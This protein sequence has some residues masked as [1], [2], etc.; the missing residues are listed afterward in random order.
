MPNLLKAVEASIVEKTG[1]RVSIG[2]NDLPVIESHSTKQIKSLDELLEAGNF[3]KDEWEVERSKANVWHQ[4]SSDNGL[5]PLWQ[6]EAR[7][8]R[9]D[10]S[11]AFIAQL[12]SDGHKALKAGLNSTDKGKLAKVTK[13]TIKG[14]MVEFAL[15]DLHLGKFAWNEETG[16][17]NWDINLAADT[18]SD[19]MNDL[20]SRSPDAEEAWYIVGNDFF[21]VD[22]ENGTTTAGTPQDE[23]GR[24]QKTFA[25]GKEIVMCSIGKLRKKYPKVKVIVVYGNHD[26][27]RSFYLGEVLVEACRS[28]PNVEVD[29]R[30]LLRKYYQWGATGIGF[31]HGDRIK[32]KDL[33][34]LVQNEA[35]QIWGN[36]KRF[37]LHLGHL[38]Q[39]IV[40]TLG[41]VT[42]R[43]LPAL[44][45]PDAWHSGQGYTMAEKAAMLFVYDQ[46]GMRNLEVHYPNEDRL[47][48]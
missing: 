46:T 3:S 45:P 41:G 14:T 37:E 4:F 26:R 44:C 11:Q 2:H 36:T 29:N 5:V 13:N 27:Q 31:T 42:V 9:K 8:R 10:L 28:I 19:A 6:V 7:L 22:N 18:Y 33:A 39:D 32:Q 34:H 23:D 48:K 30:P 16:H 24:W 1:V 20:I 38:H 15:P 12:I 43:W 21:N 35:R 25:K 47:R 17:G 40:K